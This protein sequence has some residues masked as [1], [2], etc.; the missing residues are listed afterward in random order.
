MILAEGLNV[1]VVL[2]PPEDDPDTFAHR[3][4]AAGVQGNIRTNEQD[5]LS[6]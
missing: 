5:F 4:G 6:F 3:L 2:L 1:R